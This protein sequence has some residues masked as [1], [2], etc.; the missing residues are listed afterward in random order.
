MKTNYIND[1]RS[2]FRYKKATKDLRGNGTI[3]LRGVSFVA[4]HPYIF[5][6]PNQD[7]INAEL[8]WY[9]SKDRKVQA[10][11]DIY[12]KDVAIWKNVADEYG[13]VNS[14]YGACIYGVENTS[15]SQYYEVLNALG[16]NPLSRQAVMYYHDSD[17]HEIAGKDFCCTTS[18]QHF[19]SGSNHL[20]TIVN[21]RS[22]DAVFGYMND[23][24]WHRHV[25]N[26]LAK[27]L[28]VQPGPITCNVGSLHV[29]ER[30]YHLIK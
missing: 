19:I 24:A 21:Q 10:L 22:Q 18:T 30:H 11:F 17:M 6:T 13:N 2:A 4:D 9:E 8:A 16:N 23:I 14:Q 28:K 25:N 27:A 5:G 15:V 7:Y 20:E 3:E 26:K 29:Y 12:G 1:V